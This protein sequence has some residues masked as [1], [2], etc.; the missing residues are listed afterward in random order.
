MIDDPS[1]A[2]QN[3]KNFSKEKKVK[4]ERKSGMYTKKPPFNPPTP[5]F[6]KAETI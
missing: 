1:N 4:I 5:Q 3:L 6:S 2:R